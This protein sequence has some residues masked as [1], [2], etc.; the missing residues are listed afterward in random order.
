[1]TVIYHDGYDPGSRGFALV[2]PKPGCLA[3]EVSWKTHHSNLQLFLVLVVIETGSS[4][5]IKSLFFLELAAED[6]HCV[7]YF[8][9][10]EIRHKIHPIMF[11]HI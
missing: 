8:T 2:L 7:I 10:P 6:K 9:F 1:M 11:L 3:K 5:E 4:V